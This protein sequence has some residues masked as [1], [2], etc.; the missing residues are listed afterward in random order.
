M[1]G[2][3]LMIEDQLMIGDQLAEKHQFC[4]YD[5]PGV[6]FCICSIISDT[7]LLQ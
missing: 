3:Q 7:C 1:I 6:D 2:D 4:N 5:V